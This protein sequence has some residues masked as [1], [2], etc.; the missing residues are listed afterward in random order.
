MPWFDLLQEMG[1]WAIW[2]DSDDD[3]IDCAVWLLGMPKVLDGRSAVVAALVAPFQG[4]SDK[5]RD[6]LRWLAI[7]GHGYGSPE[8][9]D[10][11]IR[12]ITDGTLD[13]ARRGTALNDD[14]WLIWHSTANELPDFVARVLGAWFDR[15]LVRAVRREHDNPIRAEPD[16]APRSQ[17]SSEVIVECS[18]RAPYEFASEL[19]AE[20]RATRRA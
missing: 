17:F 11:V 14:W 9:Q 15:K 18:S 20:I 16:L 13:D 3:C 6:R 8:M 7:R 5:W 4:R 10:L 1:R 2:L 12:L 19:H